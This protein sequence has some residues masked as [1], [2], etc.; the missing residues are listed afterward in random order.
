MNQEERKNYADS[1]KKNNTTR[2]KKKKRRA[3]PLLTIAWGAFGAIV[4]ALIVVCVL[5]FTLK[6]TQAEVA[7]Y[8]Y[9][10][11]FRLRLCPHRM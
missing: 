7:S 9:N 5:M 8:I 6:P 3:S 1:G 2:R 4:V 10:S 11:T